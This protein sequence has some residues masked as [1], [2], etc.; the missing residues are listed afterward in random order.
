MVKC[1]LPVCLFPGYYMYVEASRPRTSGQKARFLSPNLPS[2]NGECLTFYY[3]MNGRTMGTLNVYTQASGSLGSPVWTK[4]GNQGSKWQVAQVTLQSSSQFQVTCLF[5]C[6]HLYYNLC[7]HDTV[8]DSIQNHWLSDNKLV[9]ELILHQICLF[10]LF[11]MIKLF[12]AGCVWG[13]DWLLLLQ[14]HCH[15]WCLHCPWCLRHSWLM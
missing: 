8:Y 11:R 5:N 9:Q 12:V 2:S 7:D 10:D 1:T 15:W 4:S 3:N 6:I 13:C 14:R